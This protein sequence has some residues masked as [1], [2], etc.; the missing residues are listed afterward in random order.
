MAVDERDYYAILQIASNASTED[1]KAAYRRLALEHHP[2]RVDDP[3]ATEQMQRINEAYGVLIDPLK[4]EEYDLER[5]SQFRSAPIEGQF[6]SED[7]DQ[8]QEIQ[9]RKDQ[10]E[11]QQSWVRSQLKIFFRIF[12]IT[13]ALF[14]WTLVTGQINIAVL[15][16]LLVI[17]LQVI[18]SIVMRIRNLSVP[19]A[20]KNE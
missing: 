12:L 14:L 17:S 13:A 3:L 19:G 2:D 11:N 9:V 6:W 16:L 1:V 8:T 18:V 7:P 4:R 10:V 5:A 20:A 15:I